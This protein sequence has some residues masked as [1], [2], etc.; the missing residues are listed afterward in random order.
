MSVVRIAS[1]LAIVLAL[2]GRTLAGDAVADSE[3]T[4]FDKKA[5]EAVSPFV[6]VY[7]DDQARNARGIDP[8]RPVDRLTITIEIGVNA[9]ASTEDGEEVDA[10]PMTDAG[11]ELT[12]DTIER[13]ILTVLGD[14]E[15]PW[16][17][18][19]KRLFRGDPEIH[20][21]RGAGTDGIRFAGR[22][23]KITVEPL[24]EP[25]SGGAATGV[26]ADLL[27]AADAAAGRERTARMLRILIEA[28]APLDDWSTLRRNMLMSADEGSALLLQPITGDLPEFGAATPK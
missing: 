15:N 4:P 19:W 1:R 28:P 16:S 13:Q 9:K 17:S 25:P 6:S 21:A 24:K 18:I 12:L 3:I 20:S 7:T 2:R 5:A 22:Q 23:I 14:D 8:T 10:I 27:T 26:W 11:M